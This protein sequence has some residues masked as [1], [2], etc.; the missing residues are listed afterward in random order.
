MNHA[1]MFALT[2]LVAAQVQLDANTTVPL[3]VV[4]GV[5][6]AVISIAGVWYKGASDLAAVER[7]ADSATATEKAA[8]E[9]GEALAAQEIEH[10]R[11][12]LAEKADRTEVAAFTALLSTMSATM[13]SVKERVDVIGTEVAILVHDRRTDDEAEPKRRS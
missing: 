5:C 3:G 2:N 13:V 12:R 8:R 9:K 6:V 1:A 11:G 7:R 10:L 4:V